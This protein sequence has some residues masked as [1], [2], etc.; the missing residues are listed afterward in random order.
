M[1]V[2][3]TLL[4]TVEQHLVAEGLLPSDC[5]E[6]HRVIDFV[7]RDFALRWPAP[8]SE[9]LPLNLQI[10]QQLAQNRLARPMVI[11][12]LELGDDGE[13]VREGRLLLDPSAHPAPLAEAITRA[14]RA[15]LDSAAEGGSMHPSTT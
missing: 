1:S 9:P 11:W 4:E 15:L 2:G 7:H 10:T 6:L 14:C 3:L 8:L 12:R 5:E 13:R